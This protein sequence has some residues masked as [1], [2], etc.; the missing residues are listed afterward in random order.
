M[1]KCVWMPIK[2]YL[3]LVE[4]KRAENELKPTV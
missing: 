3:Q 2:R 4:S 1:G